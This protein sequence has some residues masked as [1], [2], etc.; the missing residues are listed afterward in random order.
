[1]NHWLFTLAVNFLSQFLHFR[2]LTLPLASCLYPFLVVWVP[3]QY[4]HLN[5]RAMNLTSSLVKGP[6]H[7][8]IFRQG[9]LDKYI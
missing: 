1:M 7:L 6:P 4:G 3:L 2:R 8:Y 9:A 5:G